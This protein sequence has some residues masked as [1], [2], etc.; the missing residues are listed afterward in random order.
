MKNQLQVFENEE[1]GKI[2]V[3]EIDGQPWFVGKDVSDVLGYTN[4]RK[5]LS[6]HVVDEDKL[7]YRFV[8]SGQNR[9]MTTINES[10]LYSLIL[11]SKLPAAKIF[12][13]W[14]T[15]D[16]LPSIRKHGAYITDDT[17]NR[18]REDEGYIEELIGRL[19]D[20]K[21]RNTALLG[22]V[23]S[24]SPKARHCDIILQCEN[25]VQTSIVARDYG[26]TATA[27]NKL[28]NGLKIQFKMG[29]TWLLYSKYANNG[30]TIT[31]TYHVTENH[32][33]IHSYWTQR[34]RLFLYDLLKF[35]GI[36]PAVETTGVLIGGEDDFS[37]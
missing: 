34:G 15:K 3:I 24:L 30:Y 31:R 27:F 35:Y 20:E 17:L 13:R 2:R 8:T 11:S 29:G 7:A 10:G 1:F 36:S 12:T 22:K 32:S 16:V 21:A 26:M 18:L 33:R 37:S 25:A 4:S 9:S 28:L 6:D 23:E 14:I 5:A 19:S